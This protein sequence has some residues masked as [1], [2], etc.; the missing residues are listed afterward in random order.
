MSTY[1]DELMET[2]GPFGEGSGRGGVSPV[3]VENFKMLQE[4]ATADNLLSGGSKQGRVNLLNWD[5]RGMPEGLFPRRDS[6]GTS[7]EEAEAGTDDSATLAGG[8]ARP[9]N[10][11]GSQEGLR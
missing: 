3:A 2:S 5:G 4:R 1:D 8:R 9:D 11:A 10:T 6:A 7:P